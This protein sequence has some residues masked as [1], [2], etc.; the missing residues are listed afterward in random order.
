MLLKRFDMTFK[1]F[2]GS[3]FY[4]LLVVKNIKNIHYIKNENY[5]KIIKSSNLIYIINQ[6]SMGRSIA[7]FSD[8]YYSLKKFKESILKHIP[9]ENIL[10]QDRTRVWFNNNTKLEFFN[11][12]TIEAHRGRKFDIV[13]LNN[14]S[15]NNSI[16]SELFFDELIAVY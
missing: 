13:V 4:N 11:S 16:I 9:K 5:R 1:D 3:R 14:Y 2:L 12:H 6:L 7:Y 15:F 10:K 8:D